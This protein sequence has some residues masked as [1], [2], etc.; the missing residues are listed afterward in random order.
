[1][2]D[3]FTT[4]LHL[5]KP[6]V[7]ADDNIWGGLLNADLDA[8]D[9]LFATSG[10]GTVI[11]RDS[12]NRALVSGI[13]L[14]KA[15]GNSRTIDVFSGSSLRW[16]AGVNADAESGSNVGTDWELLRYAD[17]G[18]TLLG[19]SIL[20]E[21]ES[22]LIT[23]E[24]T[25]AVGANSIWHA[26]NDTSIRPPVGS[27]MHYVG[28][29]SPNSFW[30]LCYG[31]TFVTANYPDLFALIGTTFNTGGEGVG[32]ARLPDFRDVALSGLGNM[33]GVARAL[34]TQFSGLNNSLQPTAWGGTQ[35]I[36]QANLPNVNFNVT[37]I[38]LNDPQHSHTI[39]ANTVGTGTS[40]NNGAYGVTNNNG[41]IL[42]GAAA[43]GITIKTGT[44]GNPASVQGLAAS[45][46]SGTAL[47]TVGT[48][49]AVS[50]LI[51]A[52]A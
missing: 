40:G 42:T 20:V 25:P 24:T 1:M 43:T 19:T 32:N 2:A 44:S 17:N 4:N 28:T 33:G 15:A 50:I 47:P 6:E 7:G 51:R 8:I 26:G 10:T 34:L 49:Q 27:L 38:Q 12:S 9:A 18:S 16:Q 29:T 30:L 52:L 39:G 37:N 13:A 22:G 23:F 41:S 31:Q 14:T 45:G 35:V 3:T 48:R 21:R 36:G 11:V 46:G 5:D